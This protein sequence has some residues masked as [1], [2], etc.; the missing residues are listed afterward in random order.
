MNNGSKK[1]FS[2]PVTVFR[3]KRLP[4]KAIPAGYSALIGAYDLSVPLPRTLFA[5]GQRHRV[6]EEAGWR[7]LTPRH[8]PRPT[9]GGHLTF[10]LKYEGA[11]LAVLKR[12]FLSTGPAEIEALVRAKRTG[13]YARRI[14]FFYEWLTGD[15]LDLPDAEAGRYVPAID[16]GLQWAVDGA[17][18][19]R[20]RV[21]D[22]LPGTPE[23]C[24]LVLYQG[25]RQLR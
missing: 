23:F 4:E 25:A 20:H 8:A 2:G 16:P 22:N 14:W 7:L 12:L 17:N 6:I 13:G 18:S 10:A 5:I 3:E 21:R 1:R 15:R 19:R 9:L 24:P 11:D